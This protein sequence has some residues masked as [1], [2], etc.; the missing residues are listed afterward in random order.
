M[1]GISLS[2]TPTPGTFVEIECSKLSECEVEGYG[3][4]MARSVHIVCRDKRIVIKLDDLS[5]LLSLLEVR[6]GR[7]AGVDAAVEAVKSILGNG[8][9]VIHA[10]KIDK[11][12]SNGRMILIAYAVA[13]KEFKPI[14][15]KP[16][17]DFV[18]SELAK[19]GLL[20]GQRIVRRY[21][22][23]TVAYIPVANSSYA[24][25]VSNANTAR[26]A[27]RV[28][29]ALIINGIPTPLATE[30]YKTMHRADEIEIMKR[31]AEYAMKI[32]D[33]HAGA[34]IKLKPISRRDVERFIDMAE[35][36]FPRRYA[37]WFAKLR[38][39]KTSE[40]LL[41][42]AASIADRIA[43]QRGEEE[44]AKFMRELIKA[45]RKSYRESDAELAIT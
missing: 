24:V 22:A 35:K 2:Q 30:F 36:I 12:D 39:T 27:V 40:E 25:A 26:D 1:N 3:K 16:L 13:T 31:A 9:F 33:K 6:G 42:E 20:A 17:F 28:Y 10:R 8:D 41:A 21:R 14:P 15:H 37:S 4:K 11:L 18:E 44:V 34:K 38:N 23:R 5:K 7:R 45:V 19:A 29:D 43:K 32:A